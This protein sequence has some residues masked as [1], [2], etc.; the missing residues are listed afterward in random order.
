MLRWDTDKSV[1][2][3]DGEQE[4]YINRLKDKS[5]H[6]TPKVIMTGPWER[7]RYPPG[8]LENPT[9]ADLDLMEIR[10]SFDILEI[11][12]AGRTGFNIHDSALAMKTNRPTAKCTVGRRVF[13]WQSQAHCDHPA[14]KGEH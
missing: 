3:K 5:F 14:Y 1:P 4:P 6:F 2:E 12:P 9:T 7:N 10:F 13:P 8:H 11:S